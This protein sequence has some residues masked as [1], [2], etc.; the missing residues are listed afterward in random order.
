M[1]AH[2]DLTESLGV[3]FLDPVRIA[4]ATAQLWARH[5]ISHSSAAYPPAP[6][7]KLDDLLG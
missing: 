6:R 1:Q 3:P 4:L 5:G 2:D 7:D